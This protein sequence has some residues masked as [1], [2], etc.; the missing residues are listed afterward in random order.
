MNKKEANKLLDQCID[1]RLQVARLEKDWVK[2]ND[3]KE[4]IK[5]EFVIF[6]IMTYFINNGVE[7]D[8]AKI[9]ATDAYKM[10]KGDL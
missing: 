2:E 1:Y 10:A 7:P 6:K 5:E 9:L 8:L 4:A 3:E